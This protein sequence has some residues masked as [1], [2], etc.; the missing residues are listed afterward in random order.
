MTGATPVLH[1]RLEAEPKLGTD[2]M[3]RS[4]AFDSPSTVIT[5]TCTVF[6]DVSPDGTSTAM[7]LSLQLAAGGVSL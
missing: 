5:V 2:T 1:E 6:P 3:S 4:T 7:E